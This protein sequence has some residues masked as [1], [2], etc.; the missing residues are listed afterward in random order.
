M[1]DDQ[2]LSSPFVSSPIATA[3]SPAQSTSSLLAAVGAGVVIPQC[4]SQKGQQA[5]SQPHTVSSDDSNLEMH[6]PSRVASRSSI[7]GIEIR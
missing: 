5:V 1:V 2:S 3:P 4:T 6:V 7:E